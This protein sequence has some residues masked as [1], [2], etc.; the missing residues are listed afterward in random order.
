MTPSKDDII[1]D[2]GGD[3]EVTHVHGEQVFAVNIETGEPA[4]FIASELSFVEEALWTTK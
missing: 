3:Y 1:D 4:V 2:F